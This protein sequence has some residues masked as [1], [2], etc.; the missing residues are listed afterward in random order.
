MSDDERD[1]PVR[2]EHSSGRPSL[3]VFLALF[4]A[5]RLCFRAMASLQL[6]VALIAIYLLV[7]AGATFVEKYQGAAAARAAVYDTAWFA[8]I[9][10]VLATNVLC[11]ML[12]RLPWR[13]RQIGFLVTHGGILVLLAG[14]AATHWLGVEAQLSIYEGHPNY[15]A[16]I[17]RPQRN[18][19]NEK[20]EPLELGF[21]VYLRQFRRR[22][23]PGTGMPSHYSSRVDFLERSDPPKPLKNEKTLREGVLI[24]L[25]APADFTDPQTGRTYRFFQESFEGPWLPGDAKFDQLAGPGRSR[26]QVYLS[27]LSINYD[28]GR[29]LKYVGCLMIVV[30]IAVVYYLRGGRAAGKPLAVSHA[31]STSTL[32]SALALAS[33]A[34]FSTTGNVHAAEEPLDWSTWQHLPVFS[35]GRVA[36]LDTFAREIIRAVCG[37]PNP[38]LNGPDDP[39]EHRPREFSAAELLFVWLAE[40]R[41][42]EDAA[43]LPAD[44]EQLRRDLGLPLEDFAGRRLRCI[45]PRYVKESEAVRSRLA[46]IMR[47]AEV[48]G[49]DF[50]LTDVE[51]KLDRLIDAYGAYRALTADP[52]SQHA[53]PQRFIERARLAK[54][55]PAE[56]G[57]RRGGSAANQQR[58][59]DPRR[60]GPSRRDVAEGSRRDARGRL[61]AGEDRSGRDGI[62][63]AGRSTG[64]A[65]L[66]FR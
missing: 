56:T 62:P 13:L 36:P 14:C 24:T 48:E 31:P 57:R 38:T 12:I 41:R 19:E 20:A 35:E 9:H 30:G 28:P 16:E 21:Q 40:P 42:W 15:I 46:E 59:G 17:D 11:A 22:L 50:Q 61:R 43:F 8:A 6:A 34:A 2:S 66:F 29:W 1:A 58:I 27:P 26:D 44:D 4:S 5:L 54:D 65:V 23:D 25:N 63:P 39:L 64:S 45:S 51:K 33:I 47:R 32:C 60:N 7:L 52:R 55:A 3:P 37:R 49:R 10:A 53:A 18:G